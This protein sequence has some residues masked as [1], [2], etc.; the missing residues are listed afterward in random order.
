[1]VSQTGSGS[2]LGVGEL[3]SAQLAVD[4]LNAAGGVNG[5]TVRLL[6]AD[7]Q[8]SPAQA[9]LAVHRMIGKVDALVGPSVSGPCKAV[10]P[11]ATSTQLIDYCL[12]PVLEQPL[13]EVLG[14]RARR[15]LPAVHGRL[16]PGDNGCQ[17]GGRRHRDPA[18][19][20]GRGRDGGGRGLL[21]LE[22]GRIVRTDDAATLL[23][24][25]DVSRHY[26]GVVTEE[27][28]P[29]REHRTLTLPASLD[30]LPL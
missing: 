28:G 29:A 15:P 14:R 12:L 30:R 7:D 18:R 19:G 13:R 2:Q 16:D 4:R 8:S 27:T 26:L 21:V 25:E 3:Q 23:T 11:L 24:D 20:V 6:S 22:N 9:V 17:W 5:R 1:M 10:I